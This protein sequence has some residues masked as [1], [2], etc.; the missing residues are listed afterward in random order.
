MLFETCLTRCSR[1]LSHLF[2]LLRGH[3][4]RALTAG[5]HTAAGVRLPRT[6]LLVIEKRITKHTTAVRPDYPPHTLKMKSSIHTPRCL[7]GLWKAIQDSI[8]QPIRS[9]FS[10][11]PTQTELDAL[12]LLQI[13]VP[14]DIFFG[15]EP[16]AL[17]NHA[18]RWLMLGFRLQVL[19]LQEDIPDGCIGIQRLMREGR[20]ISQDYL[21]IQLGD[22][23][24]SRLLFQSLDSETH[25]LPESN[26]EAL[27]R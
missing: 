9:A 14:Q 5:T 18:V 26:P 2:F 1:S 13:F 22:D 4:F 6:G 7:S 15:P 12:P 25:H 17:T 8:V 3:R 20:L 11:R 10:R 24:R 19:P 23:G 21:R 16:A 27:D